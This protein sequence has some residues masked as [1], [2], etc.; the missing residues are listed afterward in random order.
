MYQ[1]AANIYQV[2]SLMTV[3]YIYIYIYI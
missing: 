2:M 3:I 1:V